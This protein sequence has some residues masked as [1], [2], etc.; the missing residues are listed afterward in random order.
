[1]TG[2]YFLPHMHAHA[3]ASR[4]SRVCAGVGNDVQCAVFRVLIE[5]RGGVKEGDQP[6]CTR[7]PGWQA[8]GCCWGGSCKGSS[9]DSSSAPFLQRLLTPAHV[10][11]CPSITPRR[12]VRPAVRMQA[13]ERLPRLGLLSTACSK[14]LHIRASV[15]GERALSAASR[16]LPKRFWL[17]SGEKR[18]RGALVCRCLHRPPFALILRRHRPKHR[19]QAHW[20]ASGV[21]TRS[22]FSITS[23]F[24]RASARFCPQKRAFQALLP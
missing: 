22:Q 7:A 8:F 6:M 1:M 21:K 12:R 19:C 2:L 9:R 17:K 20:A 5:V 3:E 24:A 13:D 14:G 18:S 4:Q 10:G 16:A 11:T 15:L 23:A